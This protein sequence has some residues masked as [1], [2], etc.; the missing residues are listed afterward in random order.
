MILRDQVETENYVI[1]CDTNIYLNIY[2]YSPEFAEFALKCLQRIQDSIIVPST[3]YIEYMKH[4]R[5]AFGSRE[6]KVKDVSTGTI[7]RVQ[8]SQRKIINIC[9]TLEALHYPDIGEL[10]RGI[11]DGFGKI[12]GFVND[13]F[14]DRN[15]L[16]F[17]SG[18]WGGND[19]VYALMVYLKSNHQVMP[20]VSQENLYRYCEEGEKRYKANPPIPPGYKD[21]KNKDGIR[22]YSDYILWKEILQYAKVNRVNV[23][24]VTDDEKQDWWHK[25]NDNNELLSDLKSEFETDTLQKIAAY[26]ATDFFNELS[27]SYDIEQSDAIEIALA[28]TDDVYINRICDDVFDRIFDSLSYSGDKYIDTT[29]AH[30]GSEGLS[31]LE[32]NDYKLV[33]AEQIDYNTDRITYLFKYSVIAET[34]SFEYWGRDDDTKEI[35]LSPSSYHKFNGSILVEVVRE[36]S[37]FLDYEFDYGFESAK[38]ITGSLEEIEYVPWSDESDGYIADAY[39]TCAECGSMINTDNDGGN[40]FCT[41]CA[42][43]H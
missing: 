14:E 9:N 23:I 7:K 8:D 38:I 1:V 32:V 25:E 42:Y 39:M 33:N 28:L 40:G 43:K 30:I 37:N 24:F 15:V 3:V 2:R 18:S 19:P 36:N 4:Y 20:S 22:K 17:L 34:T 13:F 35:L 29:T 27:T 26:C 16:E 6:K 41:S 10:K 31:E 12:E 5:A 21:A 11:E